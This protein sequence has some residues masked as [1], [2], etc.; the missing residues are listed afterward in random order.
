MWDCD[1]VTP[2]LTGFVAGVIPTLLGTLFLWVKVKRIVI[3]RVS[4]WSQEES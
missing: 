1:T 2:Y 4:N 3:Q